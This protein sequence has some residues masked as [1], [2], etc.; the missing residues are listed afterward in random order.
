M[1]APYC[2]VMPPP[3]APHQTP[4]NYS[5]VLVIWC[6]HSPNVMPGSAH[7]LSGSPCLTIMIIDVV[8][9]TEAAGGQGTVTPFP[10][11]GIREDQKK[12]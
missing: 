5:A 4:F 11:R 9:C 6:T 1:L 2:S 3:A 8:S 12:K 10:P 7:L